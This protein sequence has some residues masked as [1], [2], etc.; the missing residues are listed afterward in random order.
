M[1]KDWTQFTWV[2]AEVINL[3]PALLIQ[4][5]CHLG[6]GIPLSNILKY[7]A[8]IVMHACSENKELNQNKSL[9]QASNYMSDLE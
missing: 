9:I 4:W 2:P 1:I 7:L 8:S 5:L 3:I 6:I